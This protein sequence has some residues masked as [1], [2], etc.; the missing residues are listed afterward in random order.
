M[1]GVPAATKIKS[2]GASSERTI[3]PEDL[4]DCPVIG[5]FLSCMHVSISCCAGGSIFPTSS[6]NSTPLFALCIIPGTNLSYAGVPSPPLCNGSCNT[7]PN[8]A[9]AWLPVASMNGAF[10]FFELSI[11]IFGTLT[12]FFALL[13]KFKNKM[14]IAMNIMEE[15]RDAAAI[16]SPYCFL[17]HHGENIEIAIKI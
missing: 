17:T 2:V 5:Y 13:F 7:S 16:I 8:N 12:P 1:S 11:N 4:S 15:I 9:P 6:M 14:K 10:S 3:A